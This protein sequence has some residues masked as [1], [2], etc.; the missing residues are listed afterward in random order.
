MTTLQQKILETFYDNKYAFV[1]DNISYDTLFKKTYATYLLLDSLEFDSKNIVLLS[2]E[3]NENWMATYYACLLKGVGLFIYPNKMDIALL[4][5]YINKLHVNLAFID[6]QKNRDVRERMYFK[7]TPFLKG[8]INLD[9]LEDASVRTTVANTIYSVAKIVDQLDVID[10]DHAMS[11]L[12]NTLDKTRTSGHVYTLT[13]GVAKSSQNIVIHDHDS[14]M[15]AVANVSN[16]LE[17]ADTDYVSAPTDS[18]DKFHAI[19]VLNLFLSGSKLCTSYFMRVSHHIFTT[20]SFMEWWK[21][22]VSYVFQTKKYQFLNSVTFKLFEKR[23]KY[24]IL[25][26]AIH[27]SEKMTILNGEI[28]NTITELLAKRKNVVITFGDE[29][30]NHAIA[31][32]PLDE[33]FLTKPHCIGYAFPSIEIH[34]NSN[35]TKIISSHLSNGYYRDLETYKTRPREDM[36]ITNDDISV[37]YF[38]KKPVLFF[39]GRRSNRFGG[40]P[41]D[42]FEK[43]LRGYS[44]IKT[45]VFAR[46]PHENKMVLLIEPDIHLAENNRLGYIGLTKMFEDLLA[47]FNMTYGKELASDVMM[48]T[49]G[50]DKII[51]RSFDDKPLSWTYRI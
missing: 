36:F 19:A 3:V 37:K 12:V 13:S 14:I 50:P 45:C 47:T 49:D 33:K 44:H 18:I 26:K 46:H 39:N 17:F 8:I 11:T 32:N 43:E 38:N 29:E 22:N 4:P 1:I 28:P 5:Y 7:K 31:Y 24:C 20:S 48:I 30:H 42:L 2:G 40:I 16:E 51:A 27:P 35:E 15:S 9:K 21:Y 10:T 6:T 41:Y 25:K 34:S 23:I